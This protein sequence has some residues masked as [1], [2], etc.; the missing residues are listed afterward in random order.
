MECPNTRLILEITQGL[1]FARMAGYKL[2]SAPYI[3]FFDD[4]NEPDVNYLYGVLKKGGHFSL[5]SLAYGHYM[6]FRLIFT[7]LH[8]FLL[9]II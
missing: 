7:D 6:K 9:N 2:A 8:R 3:I 1:T 4:D 5:P